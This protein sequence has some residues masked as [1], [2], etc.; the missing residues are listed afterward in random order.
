M[1]KHSHSFSKLI[2]YGRY[3]GSKIM[4]VLIRSSTK[5]RKAPDQTS[6]TKNQI[7]QQFLWGNLILLFPENL[8]SLNLYRTA[9]D[10]TTIISILCT[11]REDKVKVYLFGCKLRIKKMGWLCF[12]IWLWMSVLFENAVKKNS[13]S[14][15]SVTKNAQNHPK[16]DESWTLFSIYLWTK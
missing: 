2:N 13:F 4:C 8:V 1:S 5:K 6:K 10:Q 14:V 7:F 16:V 9:V 3:T 11:N 12:V 15:A